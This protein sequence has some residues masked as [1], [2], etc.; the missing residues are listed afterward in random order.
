MDRILAIGECP[1]YLRKS[2]TMNI[3]KIYNILYILFVAFKVI[4]VDSLRKRVVKGYWSLV[5]SY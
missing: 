3:S 2:L 4:A 1:D 5:T